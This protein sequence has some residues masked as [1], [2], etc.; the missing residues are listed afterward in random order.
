[1]SRPVE[2][3]ESG[4]VA[5]RTSVPKRLEGRRVFFFSSIPLRF[6]VLFNSQRSRSSSAF[7]G[8]RSFRHCHRGHPRTGNAAC[9]RIRRFL[10]RS[11]EDPHERGIQRGEN[12]TKRCENE[13][14]AFASVPHPRRHFAPHNACRPKISA[15]NFYRCCGQHLCGPTEIIATTFRHPAALSVA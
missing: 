7:D 2:K 4:D 5:V 15:R 3:T 9:P 13:T 6:N 10:R 14:T 12:N 8:R 1:M 11:K